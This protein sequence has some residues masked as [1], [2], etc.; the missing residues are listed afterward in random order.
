MTVSEMIRD[1]KLVDPALAIALE[2]VWNAPAR[3]PNTDSEIER[4]IWLLHQRLVQ[5]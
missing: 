5:H 2:N 1:I 4:V 3:F